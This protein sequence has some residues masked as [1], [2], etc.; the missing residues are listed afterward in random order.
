ME[1]PDE[2]KRFERVVRLTSFIQVYQF[3]SFELKNV[4]L[5]GIIA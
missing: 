4:L 1:I 3:P 5:H 2:V